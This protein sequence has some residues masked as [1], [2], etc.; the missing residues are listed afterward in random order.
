[1]ARGRVGSRAEGRAPRSEGVELIGE[2]GKTLGRI[3]SGGFGPTVGAPVAMGYVETAR[4]RPGTRFGAL[5]RGKVQPVEVAKLPFVP[6]R[7]YRG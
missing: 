1:A 7:Y 3:T 5:L 6:Q 2:D 4:A